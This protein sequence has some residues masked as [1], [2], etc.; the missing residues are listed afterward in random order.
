MRQAQRFV[1]FGFLFATLLFAAAPAHAEAPEAALAG[2]GASLTVVA[3]QG[4]AQPIDA[5]I[6]R[7]GPLALGLAPGEALGL[8]VDQQRARIRVVYAGRPLAVRTAVFRDGR[9][10]CLLVKRGPHGVAASVVG[11][12]KAD[13]QAKAGR[14]DAR[15]LNKIDR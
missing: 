5:L 3:S 9:G 13:P 4:L 2:G 10:Y 1:P 7:G 6:H 15:C 11:V 14:P 12:G 8:M